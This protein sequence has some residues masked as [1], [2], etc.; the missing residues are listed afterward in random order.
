MDK[1]NRTFCTLIL[2]LG[3]VGLM[4]ASPA[5][6]VAQQSNLELPETKIRLIGGDDVSL[7]GQLAG[8]PTLLVLSFERE[9]L[10]DLKSWMTIDSTLC[11]A[12][13]DLR[14]LSIPVLPSG[15]RFLR[16]LIDGGMADSVGSEQGCGRTATA[17]IKKE[18][19]LAALSIKSEKEVTTLLL[20]SDGAVLWRGAGVATPEAIA[21]IS[22]ALEAAANGS[23]GL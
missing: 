3:V 6:L 5:D 8:H 15:A 12:T 21:E 19:L 22:E 10:D 1:S 4:L 14:R 7:A 11:A 16:R 2:A 23:A 18:P 17:Y 13:P 20:S 9:Q